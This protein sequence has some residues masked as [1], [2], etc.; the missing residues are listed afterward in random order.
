MYAKGLGSK[1]VNNGTINLNQSGTIGMYIEDNAIGI[2]NGLIT[3]TGSGT[4]TVTGVVLKTGGTLE[5]YGKI[6]IDKIRF[7]III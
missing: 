4:N 6:Y 1:V 3:T 5:N 7:R 2:N